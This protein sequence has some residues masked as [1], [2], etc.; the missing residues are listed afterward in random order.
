MAGLVPAIPFGKTLRIQ[1]RDAR[2]TPA[3]DALWIAS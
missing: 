1:K 3:H 2:A